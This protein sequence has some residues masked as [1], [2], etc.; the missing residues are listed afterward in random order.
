M[1]E[2]NFY[3]ENHRSVV[4]WKPCRSVHPPLAIQIEMTVLP[5]SSGP[6]IVTFPDTV[7]RYPNPWCFRAPGRS[8]S[9]SR[10]PLPRLTPSRGSVGRYPDSVGCYPG[11]VGRYPDPRCPGARLAGTHPTVTTCDSDNIIAG[12]RV[13]ADIHCCC[14]SCLTSVKRSSIGIGSRVVVVVVVA[15]RAYASLSRGGCWFGCPDL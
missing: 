9:R 13:G 8:L 2:T 6:Q 4:D 1:S 15:K 14:W 11:P 10:R 3:I 7:G 12:S 5:G